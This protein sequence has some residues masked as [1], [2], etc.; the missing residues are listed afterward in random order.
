MG[1]IRQRP[2]PGSAK[3]SNIR[4]PLNPRAAGTKF[5]IIELSD[6]PLTETLSFG[7]GQDEGARQSNFAESHNHQTLVRHITRR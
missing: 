3:S 4:V 5:A 6:K 2:D 1:K 7:R